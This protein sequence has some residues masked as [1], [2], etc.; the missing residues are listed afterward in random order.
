MN[1]AYVLPRVIRHL[2]PDSMAEWMKRRK[3]LIKAGMETLE[4]QAAAQRYLTYLRQFDITIKGKTVLIF[5]YG[6]NFTTACELLNAGAHKV[7]LCEREG[8]PEQPIREEILAQ[9][10]QYFIKTDDAVQLDPARLVCYHRDIRTLAKQGDVEKADLIIS[11]SVFE[12]LDDVEGITHA[13]YELTKSKGT[14]LHFIDLRDHYFKY[15]F[16]ML[17]FSA[18]T[19]K[20]WLNPTS[21]LNRYRIPQ[22][23]AIFEEDFH[24]VTISVLESEPEA[25]AVVKKDIRAEFLSGDDDLDCATIIALKAR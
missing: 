11:S 24:S 23:R 8:F 21:N 20:N 9:Y 6:G 12:H 14:H 7:I 5:G 3:I 4:P 15:P 17:T 1:P 10:P 2:M 16:E 22:Y 19:W 18:S 13:L 25:F